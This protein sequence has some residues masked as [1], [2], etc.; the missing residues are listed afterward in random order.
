MPT[1]DPILYA[2]QMSSLTNGLA[3]WDPSPGWKLDDEGRPTQ[4]CPRVRPGDVGYMEDDG[5]FTRMF[6]LHLPED[7]KDQGRGPF[8]EY[9]EH[10]PLSMSYIA[11]RPE[12]P[13]FYHSNKRLKV[14]GGIKTTYVFSN[15]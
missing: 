11:W 8:P 5:T 6:N 2:Q 10:V 13:I 7:H 14:L 9:F 12:A 3:I 4:S 1:S 15:A